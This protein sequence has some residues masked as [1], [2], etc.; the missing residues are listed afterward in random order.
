NTSPHHRLAP[1]A[2]TPRGA[3]LYPLRGVKAGGASVWWGVGF[4]CV[5]LCVVWLFFLWFGLVGVFFLVGLFVLLLVWGVWVVVVLVWGCVLGVGVWGF[6]F[7]CCGWV[8]GGLG[9]G[10]FWV[11]GVLWL[12]GVVEV[13][14][15]RS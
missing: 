10:C 2:L 9:W 8:C 4:V 13:G 1:Q 7:G 6:L 11:G 3:A 5:V 14:V 15:E 12:G